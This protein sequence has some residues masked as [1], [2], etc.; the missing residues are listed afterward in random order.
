MTILNEYVQMPQK[1][2]IGIALFSLLAAVMLV[3]IIVSIRC[4]MDYKKDVEPWIILVAAI[5]AFIGFII[6]IIGLQGQR[7]HVVQATFDDS[8]PI[9]QVMNFYKVQSIDGKIYTLIEKA[10]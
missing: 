7:E 1:A 3:I 5:V 4:L 10:P 8:Y 9:T 2:E 6:G